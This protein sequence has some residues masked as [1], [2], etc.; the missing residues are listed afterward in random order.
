M[1][2]HPGQWE[3]RTSFDFTAPQRDPLCCT[4]VNT[5]NRYRTSAHL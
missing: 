2:D 5:Q 1:R 4:T 3:V